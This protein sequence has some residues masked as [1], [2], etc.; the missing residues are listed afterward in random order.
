MPTAN[1]LPP[2]VGPHTDLQAQFNIPVPM[3]DG[4]TLYADLYRPAGDTP[5]PTLL[6]RTPYDKSQSRTGSLDALRAASH[7]YAVVIQD[8]RGRYASEGEFYPFLNEPDDGYDTVQWCAAQPWSSGKIGMFGRSYVGATQWLCAITNPPAL[9]AIAPGITASDYYE[10]W[11]YQGGAFALGFALSWTLRQLTMANLDAISRRHNVPPD[12]RQMLRD[13]FNRLDLTFQ[14][15]PIIDLPHLQD[16]LAGYYYDWIRHSTSDDYWRRWRIEDH[17]SSLTVPALHIGGWHDIFLLGTLRNYAGM[18]NTAA[19]PVARAGQRLIVGPWHH[20]PFGE[21][22]GDYFFGLES[23]GAALDTDGLQLRWFDH[24]LKGEPNGVDADPPVRIF[25]MGRNQWRDE[26]QWPPARAQFTDYYLHSAG[27][28]N[29]AAGD[30][31]LS[32]IAPQ[33][34]PTDC[35]LYAPRHPVPTRGGPLCC[36]PSFVPGGAY[37]QQD[38]ET[39]PDILCYTTPPLDADLE[40]TGPVTLTLYAATTAADTDFTAKLVD[41]SPCGSARNLTDGIIRARYRQ[42]TDAPH[43]ITPHTIHEYAIDLVAT[44]NVFQAG[45]RIRLEISSSNFPRFDRNFN[46][47]ADP[48]AA[49]DSIPALQTIHHTAAHPSRLHLPIIPA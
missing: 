20:G 45:H 33:D 34:E 25:V 26:S 28:A 10:G 43:P 11:T 12:T 29:T 27:H 47:A 23:S 31:T 42:G 49:T 48:W 21:T 46:T 18:R 37:D 17:Y 6:Q 22:S 5:L 35:Y 9:A 2:S 38:I 15:Q 8:T 19:N 32:T 4:I 30:G 3:R 16:P 1:P 14:H 36:G 39:R 44:S 7:G 24:W 41:V 40:V 13:A